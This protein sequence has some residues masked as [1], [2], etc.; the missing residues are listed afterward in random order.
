MTKEKMVSEIASEI[1]EEILETGAVIYDNTVM[2]T[3]VVLSYKPVSNLTFN[4][5]MKRYKKPS[6]PSVFNDDLGRN[7]T[8]EFDPVYIDAVNKYN[9]DI[10]MGMIDIVI[11]LGT[12]L[13]S[14][15]EGFPKLEDD[16]WID[17]LEILDININGGNAKRRYL[18]WVKYVVCSASSDM[19]KMLDGV[20]RLSGVTEGDVAQSAQSFRRKD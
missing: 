8:N 14:I 9:Q 4:E 11:L 3:G 13:V 17:T 20:G 5:L 2:S 15:P 16:D 18:A 1:S 12:E 19:E 10:S 6:P 7:E